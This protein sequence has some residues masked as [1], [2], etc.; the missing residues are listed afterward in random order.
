MASFD[1]LEKLLETAS[2]LLDASAEQVRDL[3]LD[4]QKNIRR[5]GEAIVLTAEIRTEIYAVRPDLMPDYLRK[6]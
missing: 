5:I 4:P 6:K 2:H 3:G 1:E